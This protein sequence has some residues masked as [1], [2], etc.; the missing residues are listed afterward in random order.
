MVYI[1]NCILCVCVS[2]Q[3][4]CCWHFPI[5]VIKVLQCSYHL[6]VAVYLCMEVKTITAV[7]VWV[8]LAT[9]VY[10]LRLGYVW[11]VGA[12]VSQLPRSTLLY[13]NTQS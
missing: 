12:R 8:W 7:A 13:Q 10:G 11:A 2:E 9:A 6:Y 5:D 4:Y 3:C 1:G